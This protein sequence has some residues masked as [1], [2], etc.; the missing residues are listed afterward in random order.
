[1][2]VSRFPCELVKVLER[3]LESKEGKMVLKKPHL[4]IIA[5]SYALGR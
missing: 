2:L 4:S 5:R 1:M 3:V